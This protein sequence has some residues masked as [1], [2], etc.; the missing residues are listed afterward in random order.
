MYHNFLKVPT[1][2]MFDEIIEEKEESNNEIEL[3]GL[4]TPR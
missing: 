4:E 2:S 1:K 3:N